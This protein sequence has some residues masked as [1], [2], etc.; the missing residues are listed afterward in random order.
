MKPT[1]LFLLAIPMFAASPAETAIRQA[2]ANVAKQPSHYPFY[3]ELAAA[4][5]RR[6]GETAD[7]RYYNQAEESLGQSFAISPENFDGLKVE[8][9]IQLGRHQFEQA[10]ETSTRLNKLSPDDVAVYGVI[11]DADLALGHYQDAVTQA[12]WMLNLRE[13]NVPGLVRAAT[14]RELYGRLS[15]ALELLEKANDRLPASE[16][17][18]RARVLAQTSHVELLNGDLAKAE[19]AANAAQTAFP[20]S[21]AALAALAQVRLAQARYPEAVELLRRQSTAA[22]RT[23][24]LYTLAEA[25]ELAGEHRDAADSFR[26]FERQ[27]L[28]QSSL[29]DNANRDLIFYYLDHASQPAIALDLARREAA[30]R[31][32]VITLDAYAWALAAN[33]DYQAAS[34]ELQKALLMGVK[35]PTLL[36]HASVIGSHLNQ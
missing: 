29:A 30:R 23:E 2:A 10:L 35:D 24:T 31:Q 26:E 7:S 8:A 21:D 13:D 9:T 1:I 16:S 34:Q 5:V 14:L 11:V 27:A 3:N 12:Q 4:Y 17:E 25:Q 19:S 32:D 36:R 15:G 18:Q 28:A 22:P 20:D 33:G 6:A